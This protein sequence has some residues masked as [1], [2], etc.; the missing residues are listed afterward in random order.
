MNSTDAMYGALPKRFQMPLG[1]RAVFAEIS[2]DYTLPDY[3]PEIRRVLK[4][5]SNVFP[6]AKYI[7]GSNVEFN[8]TV[9]YRVLYVGMDGE[10]YSAP[11]SAEYSFSA[12]LDITN[13][14]DLNEGVTVISDIA[15]ESIT[16]RVSAP[17]KISIK[18]RL[19]AKVR[20]YGMLVADERCSGEVNPMSIERL[21]GEFT[22]HQVISEYGDTVQLSE[23]IAA[24]SENLRVITAVADVSVSGVTPLNGTVLYEGNVDIKL[25]VCREGE[26]SSAYIVSKKIPFRQEMAVDDITSDCRCF[27]QT[28]VGDLK[29]ALE[30]GRISVDAEMIPEVIAYKAVPVTYTRD[31]YSTENYSECAYKEYTIPEVVMVSRGNFSQSERIPAAD[32]SISHSC[33]VVDI[34]CRPMAEKLEKDK[35]KITVSGQCKYS[36]VL[37]NDGEYS[38]TDLMLPFKYETDGDVDD[39]T[40]HNVNIGV[41][42]CK[43]RIEGTNICIDTELSICMEVQCSEIISTLSEVRFGDKVKKSDG[44][45]IICFPSPEDTPWS[46]SKRYFVPM[47]KISEMSNYILVNS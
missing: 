26:I 27:V 6:P 33:R 38:V 36:F 5:E 10:L 34:S 7:G 40:D 19:N 46:I 37:E 14:F 15:E 45:I 3:Q 29:V 25:L 23:Q 30:D 42:S 2:N 47:S 21:N 16:A 41:I 24:D 43:G 12:P 9:D 13:E 17:R 35:G 4:V 28:K 11:L 39:I 44:D 1:N 20:A 18:C 31:L 8:G 32:T 22:S